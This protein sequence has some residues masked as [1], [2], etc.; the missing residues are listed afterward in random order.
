MTTTQNSNLC[1]RCG[2][3]VHPAANQCPNCYCILTPASLPAHNSLTQETLWLPVPAFV[4]SVIFSVLVLAAM[5]EETNATE[6]Y[7][8]FL[9]SCMLLSISLALGIASAAVQER[10]KGLA[11]AAISISTTL[12][13]LVIINYF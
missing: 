9:G 7:D 3:R 6:A 4:L 13:A 1:P 11:I 8:S 12:L 2:W 10:G 5:S